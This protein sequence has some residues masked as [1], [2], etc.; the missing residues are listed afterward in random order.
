MRGLIYLLLIV[1]AS[2]CIAAEDEFLK[3]SPE[4]EYFGSP[5]APLLDTKNKRRFRTVLRNGAQEP[6]NFNGHYRIIY[7]GCGANCISWAIVDQKSGAVWMAPHISESCWPFKRDYDPNAYIPDWFESK[8]QSS[9]F[10]SY[11]CSNPDGN[12]TFNI[13]HIYVWKN[14]KPQ[15]LR[16][17]NVSY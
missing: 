6:A 7:W 2:A 16:S 4:S 14:G 10:Y 1:N 12:F 17:K 8:V 11:V 13:R 5:A 9:L 3:F 15:L